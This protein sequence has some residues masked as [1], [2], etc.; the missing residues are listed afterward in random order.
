MKKV[1]LAI[2]AIVFMFRAQAQ[3]TKEDSFK[4]QKR[5]E[6]WDMKMDSLK[7]SRRPLYSDVHSTFKPEYYTRK[8]MFG[9]CTVPFDD[10]DSYGQVQ[11]QWIVKRRFQ[12]ARTYGG[13]T[14][15]I[16]LGVFTD[17][18]FHQQRH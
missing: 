15:A 1:V 10:S 11:H 3:T 7:K 18:W 9:S 5:L 2:I 12:R 8:T 16:A 13:I 6:Y 4:I 14:L 17:I